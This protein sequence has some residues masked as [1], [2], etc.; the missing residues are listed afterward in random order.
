MGVVGREPKNLHF[1]GWV[2]RGRGEGD[3][4]AEQRTK[5]KFAAAKKNIKRQKHRKVTRYDYLQSCTQNC[6]DLG[7]LGCF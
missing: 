3:D 1:W 7:S 5:R 4:S 2:E 6:A